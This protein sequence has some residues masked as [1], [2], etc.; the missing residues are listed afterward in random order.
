[1]LT[2]SVKYPDDVLTE[3]VKYPDAV[4]TDSA[5]C[6]SDVMLVVPLAVAL[7]PLLLAPVGG[8]GKNVSVGLVPPYSTFHNRGYQPRV[9]MTLQSR[10]SYMLRNPRYVHRQMFKTLSPT[11]Q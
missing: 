5:R 2:D 9:S 7:V 11:G 10:S 4:L 3:S 6:L 1:M 8:S